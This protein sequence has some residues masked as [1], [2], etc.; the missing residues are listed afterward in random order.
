MDP[1]TSLHGLLTGFQVALTP[2]NVLYCFIGC[3]LGTLIGVLPGIGPA[4]GIAI[5][6]PITSG[7]SVTTAVIML[8]G[9][10]YGAMYGG[11][12]TAILLNVPG[13]AGSVATVLDGYQMARQG[14]AGPALG[15][16]AISSFIAGTLSVIGLM[17]LAPPLA[18]VALAFGPPELFF[19]MLLGMTIVMSVSG[20][21][22][23]KGLMAGCFGLFLS[24]IGLDSQTGATR[25]TFGS[26]SLAAGLD[27]ISVVVGLFG[28]AEILQNAA[29]GKA[30]VFQTKLGSL[31]PTRQEMRDMIPTFGRCSVIGFLVGLVPGGNSAI[32]AFMAY[33]VEKKCSKHPERFG[34]GAIEGVCAPEGANNAVTGGSM[35]P[36]LTL[37]VPVSAAMA[38]LMGA[39]MM[40][41]LRP[42]PLLFEQNPQFVWG[43]I[44]SMYVGNVM[45]LVLNLPLI[46]FW[47]SLLKIPYPLLAP[48]VLIFCFIGAYTIRN[49]MY[50]VWVSIIFGA[51]G[52]AMQKARYPVAPVVV[53]LILAPMMEDA[54]RQSLSISRGDPGIFF[55][56]PMALALMV[57]CILSVGTAIAMRRRQS[58]AV[59]VLVEGAQEE[60]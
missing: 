49:N 40:H 8:A 45:L 57:L 28:I 56:R 12:T 47:A 25:F 6:I 50:D 21:S 24:T 5:L 22:M 33:D 29:Q 23:I 17:L 41:G 46:G 32:A 51:I 43:L 19:V 44:A 48:I 55:T 13:E 30:S 31:F 10:Y 20:E 38:I 14:R 9:I 1:V 34:R 59:Q 53:G 2:V 35:V 26:W 18:S 3:F 52:Y 4:A 60:N 27:V 36:M 39:M 7:L 58:K 16:S 37:A 15:I 54:L 11:S 42:G